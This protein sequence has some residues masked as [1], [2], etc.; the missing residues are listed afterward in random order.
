MFL[1][2]VLQY[3]D[4]K[5]VGNFTAYS[6]CSESFAYRHAFIY[7][8]LHFASYKS[9]FFLRKPIPSFDLREKNK[10]KARMD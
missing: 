2:Y 3:K 5:T 8:F 9:L 6:A 10:E 1:S 7:N 4:S